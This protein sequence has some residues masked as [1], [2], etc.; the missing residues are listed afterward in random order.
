MFSRAITLLFGCFAAV[1]LPG[2]AHFVMPTTGE[3]NS[4]LSA[5]RPEPAPES[6]QRVRCSLPIVAPDS[7]S[8][9]SLTFS[10]SPCM[11]LAWQQF[12]QH[13][14]H[15]DTEARRRVLASLPDTQVGTAQSALLSSH[16]S[17][18]HL[19]R[20][21]SQLQLLELIPELPTALAEYFKWLTDHQQRLLETELT[22]Q[23]LSRLNSQQQQDIQRLQAEIAEK[24]AQIQALT[25]IEARL[26]ENQPDRSSDDI[27]PLTERTREERPDD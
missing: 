20:L 15:L 8:S 23:G 10:D 25:E 6:S 22:V 1:A 5:D 13:S 16:P 24:T 12:M 2:C 21:H 18:P 19:L 17:T 4:N 11:L 3:P 9:P 14:L 27:E 26:S 7:L